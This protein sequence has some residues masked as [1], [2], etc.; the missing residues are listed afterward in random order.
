MKFNTLKIRILSWFGLSVAFILLV[1]SL[2]LYYLLNSSI[3]E[4]IKQNLSNKAEIVEQTYT[5]NKINFLK[6]KSLTPYDIAL[7]KNGILIAKNSS[8]DFS[9][10]LK[11]MQNEKFKIFENDDYVNAA[12]VLDIPTKKVKIIV[13]KKDIDDKMEDIIHIMLVSESLLLLFLIILGNSLINKTL[14]TIKSITKTAKKISIDNFTSTIPLPKYDDETKELVVAFNEMVKR[15]QDG[16]KKIERFNSDVSHELKTPLT[17]IK[18]EIEIASLKPR[19]V[20]YYQNI[21]KKIET[22]TDKIQTI[23]EN[24]LLLTKYTKENIHHTFKQCS[25]EGILLNTLESFDTL[26]QEK[27]I[28]LHI[29]KLENININANETLINLIFS[30]L[31]DNAVKYTPNEKNIDISLYKKD[32]YIYFIIK[33]EGIGIPK[34]KIDK[35]T[36][37]FYRVD[38][39]RSKVVKGFGLGLSL[40]K[41]SVELHGGTLQVESKVG[42]GTKVKVILKRV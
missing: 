33:D 19:D 30:N 26:L 32:N 23:I 40:V 24:L 15:L 39:S 31:I 20:K 38:E 27:Q 1:F 2:F 41:N 34:E 16:A 9:M 25:L 22:Q 14:W 4:K 12:Y 17:V 35:I 21:L 7:Y 36:D 42:V 3:N 10:L 6:Q 11:K 37:R 5:T 18:G 29:K 8:E 13:Y 28:K